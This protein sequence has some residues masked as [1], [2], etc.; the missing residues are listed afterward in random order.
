MAQLKEKAKVV[1][2]DEDKINKIVNAKPKNERIAFTRKLKKIEELV[3][4]LEPIEAKILDITLNE[5]YPILDEIQQLRLTMVK[6]CVH[7][8]DHLVIYEAEGDQEEYFQCKFCN[9]VLS[10]N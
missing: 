2:V 7:P 10:V 5:K 1:E 6:E 3:K 4:S 8:K 9:A